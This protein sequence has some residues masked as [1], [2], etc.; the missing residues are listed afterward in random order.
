MLP[1]NAV[2]AAHQLLPPYLRQARIVVDATAGNG[3]D[4]LFLAMNTPPQTIIW[5]FDIQASAIEQTKQTL[6][7]AGLEGKVRL[8]QTSH[9]QLSVT[10]DAP[11]D[12]VMFNLGYLP[13][14]DRQIVTLPDTTLAAV[15]QACRLLSP[16]GI[17]TIV[18]YPGHVSGN[19][20]N[21]VLRQYLTALPQQHFSVACWGMLNQKNQPP[22]LYAV[23]KRRE[24]RQ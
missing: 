10:I 13:G 12:V 5:S 14:G 18:A 22:L 4:T 11:V 9:E 6:A 16:G 23:E 19:Q 7:A 1:A 15:E 8:R 3:K 21:T 20:E 2:Q 24:V 17:M